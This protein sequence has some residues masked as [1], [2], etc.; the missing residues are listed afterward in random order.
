[1]FNDE[2]KGYEALSQL[3]K[4]I[5]EL[6]LNSPDS[7]VTYVDLADKAAYYSQGYLHKAIK[8]ISQITGGNHNI[9]FDQATGGRSSLGFGIVKPGQKAEE[10][11]V[12]LRNRLEKRLKDLALKRVGLSPLSAET[13]ILF[14][15]FD[16]KG[17]PSPYVIV[18]NGEEKEVLILKS[19]MQ[20]NTLKIASGL[21]G[22]VDHKLYEMTYG[23]AKF[24]GLI[25]AI[26]EEAKQSQERPLLLK[27]FPVGFT[28]EEFP[29][30]RN[31]LLLAEI[32]KNTEKIDWIYRKQLYQTVNSRTHAI[33]VEIL[34]TA[35]YSSLQVNPQYPHTLLLSD[36]NHRA[37]IE[38]PDSL[39]QLL[40]TFDEN[41]QIDLRENPDEKVR[42]RM[43]NMFSRFLE[44]LQGSG[45]SF[46]KGTGIASRS[47]LVFP[48]FDLDN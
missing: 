35:L 22:Y 41:G 26:N 14:P 47:S 20:I 32:E 5:L 36:G 42:D 37:L 33:Y 9:A 18:L 15:V 2:R 10:Q 3:Q 16:T 28:L 17:Y 24:S 21:T 19:E 34:D 48:F 7:V 30:R 45:V 11:A 6:L 40:T 38:I 27:T 44:R 12:D 8:E 13:P 4:D 29:N 39:T 23:P 1:M 43:R 31:E 46:A 25:E